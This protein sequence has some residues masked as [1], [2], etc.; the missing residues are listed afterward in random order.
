MNFH[1]LFTDYEDFTKAIQNYFYH[2]K[3]NASLMEYLSSVESLTKE[4]LDK[5]SAGPSTSNEPRLTVTPA[6]MM[7]VHP[8]T[9]RL[10]SRIMMIP[11]ASGMTAVRITLTQKRRED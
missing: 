5:E 9:P 6:K 4:Y 11:H 10:G 7:N 1:F 3:E 8:P 2:K